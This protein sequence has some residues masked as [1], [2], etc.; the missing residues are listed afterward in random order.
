MGKDIWNVPFDDITLMLKVRTH[1]TAK[2][3]VPKNPRVKKNP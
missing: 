1:C 3:K 2:E